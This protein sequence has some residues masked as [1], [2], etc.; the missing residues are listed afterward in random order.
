MKLKESIKKKIGI[1]S[2]GLG[3]A[4][5]LSGCKLNREFSQ[6]DN[7]IVEQVSTISDLSLDLEKYISVCQDQTQDINYEESHVYSEKKEVL[8]HAYSNLVSLVESINYELDASD[9]NIDI[10]DHVYQSLLESENSEDYCNI[11]SSISNYYV[12]VFDNT[13]TLIEKSNNNGKEVSDEFYLRLKSLIEKNNI[14]ELSLHDMYSEFDFSKVDLSNIKHLQFYQ[15]KQGFNV[16]SLVKKYD[17]INFDGESSEVALE[18]IKHCDITDTEIN[19]NTRKNSNIETLTK[20][21]NL[22]INFIKLSISDENSKE[23]LNILERLNAKVVDLEVLWSMD[24]LNL[25]LTTCEN[26]HTM[27][28]S[29]TAAPGINSLELGNIAIQSSC[30]DFNL[31]MHNIELTENTHFSLP[32]DAHVLLEYVP[33]INLSALKDLKNVE[34]IHFNEN[35][36]FHEETDME[37]TITY[38]SGVEL[39]TEDV[40]NYYF[41]VFDRITYDFSDY[42]IYGIFDDFLERVKAIYSEEK[43]KVKK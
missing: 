9:I 19:I 25:D 20:Y 16:E 12:D 28:I 40:F 37:N 23:V 41:D 3:L 38:Y 7:K 15:C 10:D 34:Y 14:E 35:P 21:L 27:M 36:G 13:L 39:E 33:K 5:I 43:I 32:D 31:Y 1:T 22:P 29:K 8:D 6:N 30:P 2:L 11:L 4:L 24:L 42:K 26:I 17:R 18:L